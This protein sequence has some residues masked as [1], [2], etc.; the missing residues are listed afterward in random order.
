MN[1]FAIFFK[2][3]IGLILPLKTDY[4]IS[5]LDL[6][7][8]S[9]GYTLKLKNF[10]SEFN[11]PFSDNEQFRIEH[12]K[13]GDYFAF[14][15]QLGKPYYF[16]AIC[17]KN[18]TISKIVDNK[19]ITV[20]QKSGEIAAVACAILRTM[21]TTKG[22]F[23]NAWY[24]CDLKVNKKYQ[25]EHLPLLITKT[26]AAKRFLQCPRGFGIC[27]N[28]SNGQPK[29][30]KIF[31]NHGPFPG[32]TTQILNLFTLTANQVEKFNNKIKSLLVKY[33][34]MK[35][36]QELSY[37]STSGM[38]DYQIFNEKDSRPWNLLHIQPSS[39]ASKPQ[40]DAIHMICSIEGSGLDNDFKSLLGQPSSTAE[41]ISY[42]M[43]DFDFNFL[44]TNQI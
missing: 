28:P 27:M 16:V 23:K 24:I 9:P 29:A 18:K 21:K 20:E 13:N 40:K 44:T 2:I 22:K 35:L 41:I 19:N 32:L 7:N 42:G 37:I 26:V 34:Y 1:K 5:L 25:G 17:K 4:K 33:G 12:G 10:E 39:K 8:I 6:N 38:K 31:K 14:F 43:K 15:K 36:E 11:Y 3:L 30:A